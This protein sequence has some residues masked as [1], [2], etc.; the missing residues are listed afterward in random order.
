MRIALLF[1]VLSIT[2]SLA[3]AAATG[4]I[5]GLVQDA[6]GAVI[7]DVSVRLTCVETGVV[8][9]VRTDAAGFFRF[10]ALPL[11]HYDVV[12]KKD[13]F[14]Q[15]SRTGMTIDVDT[16]LHAD[17]TLQVGGTQ[18]QITVSS[19]QVQV[20]T[21]SAQM[22]EVIGGQEITDMPL[23]G[24]AYTDLLQLQP[25]VVPYNTAETGSI[26]PANLDNGMLSMAGGQDTHSGYI[27]NGA[28]VVEGN[29]GGT[30]VM[31]TLDSI[32][33]FRIITSDANAEYGNYSGGLVNVVTK[34][35][36]N[37]Y[38]G[39][40]FEFLRNTDLDSPDWGTHTV[41]I[42]HQNQ[43]GATL[44]GPIWRKK[45]FFFGDWQSSRSSTPVDHG[46]V[47]VPSAA[48]L[49]GNLDAVS[50][51]NL[52][53][54]VSSPYFASL[55]AGRLGTTVTQGEP[56]Y[57][58]ATQTNPTTKASYGSDCTSTANC[59]FPNAVIPS[60]A[61]DPAAKS[62][63]TLFPAQTTAT[64]GTTPGYFH[65]P[66][67]PQTLKDDKGA[68]R[69]DADTK[70]GRIGGY[71]HLDPWTFNQP[72]PG[73][74]ASSV[75]GFP[76]ITT[77]K[78]QLYVVSLTSNFGS[79]AVNLLN[80]SQT[81]N[82]NIS[83]QTKAAPSGWTPASW[84]IS[85]GPT[86]LY[87]DAPGYVNY[88]AFGFN[89]YYLGPT[90]SLASQVN[91]MYEVSDDFSKVIGSHTL[92]FGGQYH[93]DKVDVSHP[94]NASNGEYIFN[95]GESGVDFA[96][97]LIGAVNTYYQGAPA[98]L[99]LRDYYAGLYGQDSWR[100][101]TRLT[102][103]LGL[104][105]D[106]DPWWEDAHNRSPIILQGVQSKQFPTAP[107]GYLFPGDAG[108]S[109]RSGA[110]T[111]FNNFS[112]RIGIAY[113][114]SFNDGVL[115][116]I[117][118]SQ[119][120]SSIRAGYG[121]YY[122]N[123]Q[124][125]NTFNFAAPPYGEFWYQSYPVLLSQPFFNYQT[126]A[127]IPNPFP[128]T[129]NPATVDWAS[130]GQLNEFANPL[131]HTPTPY[132][133]HIDLSVERSFGP[134]TMLTVSY[135]GTFGHHLS[136]MGDNNPGD[137]ALCQS[138]SQP[139]EVLPNTPTCGPYQESTTFYPV[140]GGVVNGTR[141][142]FGSN[143]GANDWSL[144]VGNSSFNA[145]EATLRRTGTRFSALVG[146][147]FSK[148]I[149]NGSS[150]GDQILTYGNH[151]QFRSLSIYNI[152]QNFVAS[153]TWEMPWDLLVRKNNQ[154]TRGWKLSG[155]VQYV[156]GTPIQLSEP[157]DDNSLTGNGGVAV[158]GTTDLPNFNRSGGSPYVDKN[159]RHGNAYLNISL[160]SAE[161]VG[162]QGNSP[163]RML[164]QPGIDN[165]NLAMLKDVKLH[166]G[167]VF[168][169]RA[170]FF[171]VFNHAQF[172]NGIDGSI[173]DNYPG[174]FGYSQSYPGGRVGQLA[175]K[176]SF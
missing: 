104:R 158:G 65:A 131:P 17:A 96:D 145:L 95:G 14:Q 150:Y 125:H 44:G 120:T 28:N 58:T 41:G 81:K 93:T 74:G 46:N 171:N 89:G 165:Y 6:S 55:L 112:P 160:W 79:S 116:S 4:T 148:A 157:N 77:G 166:E 122:T 52:T 111:R 99:N 130:Y 16:A 175:A 134:N 56:Y 69:I 49:Q 21:E 137:P 167:I 8:Q 119:G 117:F 24:R 149:D 152:P 60:A 132:E 86:G 174:G 107:L 151:N 32:A 101:N 108:T 27:V 146:Y 140:A 50:A 3:F 98:A 68:V 109:R 12:F 83:G 9:T 25:G 94:D 118:G 15:F 20:D 161:A 5:S 54:S 34:S 84:N 80:L 70:F 53:G 138:L 173:N 63:E 43:F 42:Y 126:G 66:D 18:E 62:V 110:F 113:A 29:Y 88:P 141:T 129:V 92:K 154:L 135:V 133:E 2:S 90:G 36:T 23:A 10:S 22:G 72:Y 159:P 103:N 128:V 48:D 121:M 40:A 156:N 13:G 142:K 30:F 97:M 114:P 123:V 31:P 136:V 61:W 39:N 26:A 170:E 57:Y 51:P 76:S 82:T 163:K 85:T 115:H 1:V 73:Y 176:L 100:V 147:T 11:G 172:S 75:P 124:G 139:S 105:W 33:E 38:H 67:E 164:V 87:S 169:F 19:A 155:N 144:D 59:V 162:T 91:N 127:A 168:E 7:P 35:G 64:S 106:V 143:F 47:F 78:A 71:Y 37:A 45:L 153:S 102:M